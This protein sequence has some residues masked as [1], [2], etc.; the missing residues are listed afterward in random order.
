LE[1]NNLISNREFQP[2][3]E[4]LR[5][6]T[7]LD[8]TGGILKISMPDGDIVYGVGVPQDWYSPTGPTWIYIVDHGSGLALMD[9]GSVLAQEYIADAFKF[10]RMDILDVDR[11]IITHSHL[12]HDGGASGLSQISGGEIW[13]HDLY[14]HLRFVSFKQMNSNFHPMLWKSYKDAGSRRVDEESDSP[15]EEDV[16]RKYEELRKNLKLKRTVHDGETANGFTF[17][18]TPGHTAD[19]LTIQYGSMFFTG[20]HVLPEISPHPTMK[21]S[22]QKSVLESLPNKY[23]NIE[24]FYGLETYTRS[25]ARIAEYGDRAIIMP[26]HRLINKGKIN[27]MTALRAQSIIDHHAQRL[28]KILTLMG[29]QTMDLEK[30]TRTLFSHIQLDGGSYLSAASETF[31]HIELLVDVGDINFIE[32]GYASWNG[33]ENY[34]KLFT[35]H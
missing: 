29:T 34:K 11:I 3:S 1:G 31:A 10:L 15:A 4:L 8:G 32:E 16:H 28:H 7:E 26:A 9:A 17:F 18:H 12:D 24:S 25:L 5:Q 21:A 22:F 19:E 20:D 14:D 27:V 35:D 2:V 30:I 23:S 13:A 6:P 33:S